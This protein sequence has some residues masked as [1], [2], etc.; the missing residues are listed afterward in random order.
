[1]ANAVLGPTLA[2]EFGLSAGGLGL[3]SSVYFLSFAVF[4]VPLGLLLDR[5]GPRKVNASLLLIAALGGAAFA[6][7]ESAGAAIAARALIGV[8]VSACLM[9]SFTA[10]VLWYPPE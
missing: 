3:L 9:A 2:A 8:G 6:L 5:F 4:Q 7:A 10:Y 1:M